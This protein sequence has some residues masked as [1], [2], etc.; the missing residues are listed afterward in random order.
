MYVLER[1]SGASNSLTTAEKEITYTYQGRAGAAYA[2]VNRA[3][4]PEGISLNTISDLWPE[5]VST[6]TLPMPGRWI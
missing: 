2:E 3:R 5:T 1:R 6:V 4:D